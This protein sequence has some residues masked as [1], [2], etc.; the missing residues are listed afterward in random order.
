[1][2][3]NFGGFRATMAGLR[4][5]RLHANPELFGEDSVQGFLDGNFACLIADDYDR[6]LRLRE[7]A[8]V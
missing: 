2:S 6:M 7:A 8:S 3:W 4:D 5:G 1:M